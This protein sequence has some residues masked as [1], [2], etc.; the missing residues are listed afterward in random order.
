MY[1]YSIT[2]ILFVTAKL[3]VKEMCMFTC[4]MHIIHLP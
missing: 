2:H 3:S 1:F 4:Y